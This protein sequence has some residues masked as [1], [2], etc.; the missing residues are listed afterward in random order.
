MEDEQN[1]GIARI[2]KKLDR[3]LNHLNN[4]AQNLVEEIQTLKKHFSALETMF[5]ILL[6]GMGIMIVL[7]FV[8]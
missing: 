4:D 5:Y 7:L 2:E 1:P 3:I 6:G 8:R